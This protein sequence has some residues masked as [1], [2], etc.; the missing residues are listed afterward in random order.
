[1]TPRSPHTQHHKTTTISRRLRTRADQDLSIQSPELPRLRRVRPHRAATLPEPHPEALDSQRQKSHQDFQN[2]DTGDL[3]K[4]SAISGDSDSVE[5]AIDH[6]SVHILAQRPETSPHVS[7]RSSIPG[8]VATE[9][10][11]SLEYQQLQYPAPG[12]PPSLLSSAS[13]A[14]DF[15]VPLST[16]DSRQLHDP[17]INLQDMR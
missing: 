12:Y 9:T 14:P 2:W 16:T 13:G 17:Y 6:Q 4:E 3:V 5:V 11:V 10:Q 15:E 8:L 7:L 1:M